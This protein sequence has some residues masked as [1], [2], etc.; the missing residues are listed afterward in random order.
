MKM[1]SDILFFRGLLEVLAVNPTGILNTR[2]VMS[3]PQ[4]QADCSAQGGGQQ[5][6]NAPNKDKNPKW[7]GM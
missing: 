7:C 3:A 1:F 2:E 5:E 4:N 6:F